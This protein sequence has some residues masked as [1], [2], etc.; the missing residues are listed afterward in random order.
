MIDFHVDTASEIYYQRKELF[1]NSLSVDIEKLKKSNSMAQFFA[2]FIDKKDTDSPFK[3]T[4][5]MIDYFEKEV[6]LNRID[7]SICSSYEDF[8]NL[9]DGQIAAFLTIEEGEALEG[10]IE[11]LSKFKERNISL[12]TLLWNYENSIGYPNIKKDFQKIGLKPFGIEVIKEMNRLKM[13]IDTSHLSDGGFID[14]INHSNAPIIASH[15]NS[16]A[17]TNHSRNLSDS[18]IRRLSDN[19]GLMGMN[20]SN[21][22][23]RKKSISKL[24]STLKSSNHHSIVICP[25]R[26][27]TTTTNSTN[28]R[29]VSTHR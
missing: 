19:G 17:M 21:A 8:K 2:M 22:F 4:N 16:R 15:S 12:I 13:I 9:S 25:L 29:F 20:F 23:M 5:S 6:S 10:K 28:T 26:M 1:E 14:A 11:N 7:I 24:K 3:L 27:L 18:M